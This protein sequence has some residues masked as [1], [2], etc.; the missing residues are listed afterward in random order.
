MVPG[1]RFHP[2]AAI[3]RRGGKN[4]PSAL[5]SALYSCRAIR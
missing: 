4:R 1:L 5:K 2:A 3:S